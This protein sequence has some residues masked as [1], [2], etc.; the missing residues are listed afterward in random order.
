VATL[1]T[2]FAARVLAEARCWG[3]LP[4]LSEPCQ[5]LPW[6]HVWV[7]HPALVTILVP[8]N[9]DPVRTKYLDYLLT[10]VQDALTTRQNPLAQRIPD[11]AVKEFASHFEL[12]NNA[13]VTFDVTIPPVPEYVLKVAR[14]ERISLYEA[15]KEVRDSPNARNFRDW[16]ATVFKL[17]EEGVPRA[18]GERNRMIKDFTRWCEFW[19]SDASEGVDYRTRTLQLGDIPLVEKILRVAGM[20]ERVVRDPVITPDQG[21][22][23]FLFLN[24]LLRLPKEKT[25]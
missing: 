25:V 16:C 11:N 12:P 14:A 5:R 9:I 3:P 19:A 8:L 24:D 2:K 4:R 7:D 22:R 15:T 1:G 6:S 17:G 18:T 13:I 10:K 23:Y 20:D 21:H